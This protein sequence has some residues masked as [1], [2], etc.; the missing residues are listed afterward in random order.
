MTKKLKKIFFIEDDQ[1]IAQ[2]I[3]TILEELGKFEVI[4]SAS[5]LDALQSMKGFL[6]D[7]VLLDMMMPYIDGIEVMKYMKEMEELKNVPVIFLTAKVKTEDQEAYF[8]AGAIGVIKKPFNPEELC[9]NINEI[10]K[11][12]AKFLV[13]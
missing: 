1:D 11:S 13:N 4:H 3:V 10:W 7:L 9:D 6:P 12:S 2:I 8:E 5:G